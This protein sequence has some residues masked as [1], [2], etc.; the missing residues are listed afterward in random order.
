MLE[1]LEKIQAA[2]KQNEHLKTA[3]LAE[4]SEL[5][6]ENETLLTTRQTELQQQLQQRLTAKETDYQKELSQAQQHA[7][8]KMN[9]SQA[10]LQKN[11]E[12]IKQAAV[13]VILDKVRARYGS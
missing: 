1:A 4:L 5:K 11:Y 10:A 12:Q 8:E 7:T 3:L 13:T 6:Q 2:E 9:Q